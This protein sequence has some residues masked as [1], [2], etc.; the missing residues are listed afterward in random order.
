[1]IFLDVIE[2]DG[3]IEGLIGY[4]A[5]LGHDVSY[6]LFRQDW[7]PVSHHTLIGHQAK[8]LTVSGL[9]SQDL[10]FDPRLFP[11]DRADCSRKKPTNY[12]KTSKYP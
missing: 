5:R 11:S 2:V 10:I 6:C 7:V 12:L 9:D 3:S 8:T 1:M 4:V